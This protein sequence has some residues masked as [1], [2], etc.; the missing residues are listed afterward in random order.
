M[1]KAFPLN[2]SMK[3]LFFSLFERKER[4][5]KLVRQPPMGMAVKKALKEPAPKFYLTREHVWKKLLERRRHRVPPKE[6]PHRRQMWEEIEQA[7]A[8]RLKEKPNEDEW[9]AL[10]Y[11]L[12]HHHPS[13]FFL[14]E[15][16]ARRLVYRQMRHRAS[17]SSPT[18]NTKLQTMRMTKNN[19]RND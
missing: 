10:D 9:W 3:A 16:Y 1:T 5:P 14:T 15:E 8:S 17:K 18:K 11:V 7:L 4:L 19:N 12:A 2:F 13:S 6:K